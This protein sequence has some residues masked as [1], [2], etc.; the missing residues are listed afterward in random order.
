MSYSAVGFE[1]H[2][3]EATAL[4]I[5]GFKQ[6][7]TSNKVMYCS[8]GENV[9]TCRNLTPCFPKEQWLSILCLWQL[10]RTKLS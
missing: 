10:H 9:V 3:N 1:F 2:I 7:F 6:K 5:K 8:V 4:L